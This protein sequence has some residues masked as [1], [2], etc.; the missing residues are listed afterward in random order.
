MRFA[1]P[2]A[3]A[4][5]LAGC[6]TTPS[7][8]DL[9]DDTGHLTHQFTEVAFVPDAQYPYTHAFSYVEVFREVRGVGVRLTGSRLCWETIAE[10]QHE[11]YDIDIP[12]HGTVRLGFETAAQYEGQEAFREVYQGVDYRG[13]PV[14]ITTHFRA[15]DYGL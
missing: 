6:Q 10:C 7:T 11:D 8:S 5:L 4:L 13:N 14:V 9:G 12:P 15:S 1:L 3:A 2:L